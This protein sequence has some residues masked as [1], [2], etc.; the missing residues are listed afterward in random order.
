M[1]GQ[2]NHFNKYAPEDIP[3]AKKRKSQ[4]FYN[5]CT[6]L[7]SSNTGYTE[8]TKRLYSVLELRL[9]EDGGRDWLAG[10]GRGRYSLAD[11]NV[12]AWIRFHKIA[13]IESLDQWPALKV[14]YL[15]PVLARRLLRGIDRSYLQAWVERAEARPGFQAGIHV[16]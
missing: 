9:N 15:F 3:Y 7:I 16:P 1:Q 11:L 14:S 5:E 6:K 2:A 4:S 10:P 13:G 8:E 12:I